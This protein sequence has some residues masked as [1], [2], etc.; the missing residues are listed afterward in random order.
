ML[1]IEAGS[2]AN[3]RLR[4]ETRLLRPVCVRVV[5]ELANK[6]TGDDKGRALGTPR[7]G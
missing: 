6:A 4:S 5:C 1:I 3:R 7:R 2:G